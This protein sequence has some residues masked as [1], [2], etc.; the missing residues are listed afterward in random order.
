[1]LVPA[2]GDVVLPIVNP[3][4]GAAAVHRRAP[5]VG[6]RRLTIALGVAIAIAVCLAMAVLGAAAFAAGLAIGAVAAVGVTSAWKG[7]T[8]ERPLDGVAE[9]THSLAAEDAVAFAD[10]LQAMA[11]GDLTRQIHL[12]GRPM[13]V[14][15]SSRAQRLLREFNALVQRLEEGATSFNTVTDEPCQRLFYIG[16]DG[17]LQG[18]ECARFLADA[19]GGSGQV[20]VITA[21]FG[22]GGLELRRHGFQSHLH[23][24]Y[25][26]VEIVDNVENQYDPTRTYELTSAALKRFPR[27]AGIYCTEGAGVRGAAQAIAEAG[28]RGK[29]KVVCHDL[30][31]ETMPFVVDGTITATVGQDPY[32]QGHDTA[33]HL[34]NHVA[35]GWQPTN[36]QM[37]TEMDFVTS[38]NASRFW[39]KGRGALESPEMAARRPH[40]AAGGRAGIRI[41]ILGLEDNPFWDAVRA[42][43]LAAAEE[44]RPFGATIDWI[45]PEGHGSFDFEARRRA[46]EDLLPAGYAAMA[47]PIADARFV[48]TMNRVA[49]RGIVVATFNAETTSLRGLLADLTSRAHLLLSVSSEIADTT[50]TSR[51]A[52]HEIAATIGQ[53]ASAVGQEAGAVNKVTSTIQDLDINVS[54]IATSARS[55][56]DAVDR[57]SAATKEI[58]RA[59]GSASESAGAVA[60]ATRESAETAQQGIDAIRNTLQ[61]MESIQKAVDSSAATI[62]ET[63]ELSGRIGEIVVTIDEIAD[64]TNLLALN[65]A[66]EAARAGEQGKGFAVVADEVRKL[67]ERSSTATKEIATIVRTVQETAAR[68]AAAMDAATSKV[69]QGTSLARD[70]GEAVDGLLASAQTTQ[71]QTDTLIAAHEAVAT[72][73]RDLETVIQTVSSGVQQNMESTQAAARSISEALLMVENVS[74]ISEENAAAAERVAATTEEVSAQTEE[75]NGA[76][77]SLAGFARE[78][79]A[80]TARFTIG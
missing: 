55:Q 1:V 80:A 41:A 64:Q 46:V 2:G 53:I 23:D 77:L 78:L 15:G 37:L 60:D 79:E 42:G 75:V 59:I 39:Q 5:V 30:V 49:S 26:S 11:Q 31:D 67:A 50:T 33:I 47:T 44:V 40:P 36:P 6:R 66:I 74:A 52:T 48:G 34:F 51:Q 43:V 63:N 69:L 73:M 54:E 62:A 35:S 71:S 68:A 24:R 14:V 76:A 45:V 20:L 12:K 19:I 27:L 72:V 25:P 16:A 28:A 18:Q 29:V 56:A 13:P 70:S 8:V 57:L 10:A 58:A 7:A 61:Q 21:F 22:H 32:G 4:A 65:A 17:F 9:A 3:D 38:E